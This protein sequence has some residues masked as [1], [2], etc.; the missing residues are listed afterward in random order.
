[1]GKMYS[2]MQQGFKQVGKKFGN[3]DERL[4]NVEG[5]ISNVNERLGVGTIAEVQQNHMSL[6]GKQ[7]IEIIEMLTKRLDLQD[8]AIKNKSKAIK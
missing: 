7:H 8:A 6:N 5:R 2:E 4:I 1:M 3:V